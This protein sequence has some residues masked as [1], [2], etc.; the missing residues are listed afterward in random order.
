MLKFSLGETLDIQGTTQSGLVIARGDYLRSTNNQ[1]MLEH[2]DAEGNLVQRW[3][4]EA[5]LS[6]R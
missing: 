4:D 5:A 6:S 3:Y 1:Y 2:V